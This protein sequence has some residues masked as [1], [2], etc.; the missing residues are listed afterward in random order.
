MSVARIGCV[1]AALWLVAADVA[2][3][4]EQTTDETQ[5]L[6]VEEMEPVVLNPISV[7]ATRNPIEAY[8]YPGMVSVIGRPEIETMQPWGAE[9]IQQWGTKVCFAGGPRRTADT[10]RSRGVSGPEG[11][12]R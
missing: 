5:S 11:I 9:D 7:T 2:V 8:E 3:A 4:Q 6:D 12:V 10:P 1:F